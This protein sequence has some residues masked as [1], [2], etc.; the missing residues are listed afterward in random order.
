MFVI[1][2]DQLPC[3]VEV[4]LLGLE[5][6]CPRTTMHITFRAGIV[7]LNFVLQG[8]PLWCQC[9]DRWLVSGVMCGT[10]VSSPMM[11]RSINSLPS[12]WYRCRNVIAN[13][14]H[15]ILVWCQLLCSVYLKLY[16][17][18]HFTV[19]GN[20]NKSLHLQ[21]LQRCYCENSGS[22]A[23]ACIMWCRYSVTYMQSLH[24]I[25]VLR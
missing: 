5:P 14:M 4:C 3:V 6:V 20:W 21:L 18:L 1:P 19:G 12:S 9:I 24:A 15:F 22:P 10:Y 11:I 7:C 23:S 17:R 8:Y 13:S 16:H 25:N 2:W